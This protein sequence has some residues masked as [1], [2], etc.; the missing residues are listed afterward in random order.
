LLRV[1]LI[2][3][4]DYSSGRN[5]KQNLTGP[6][7]AAALVCNAWKIFREINPNVRIEINQSLLCGFANDEPIFIREHRKAKGL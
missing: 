1:G 4:F 7:S 6:N 5:G 3:N 2:E